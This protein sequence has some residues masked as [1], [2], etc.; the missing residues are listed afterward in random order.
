MPK[1]P[2]FFVLFYSDLPNSLSDGESFE[3]FGES[4]LSENNN[5][6]ELELSAPRNASMIRYIFLN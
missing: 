1:H 5:G 2:I 3:C 4:D 6:V